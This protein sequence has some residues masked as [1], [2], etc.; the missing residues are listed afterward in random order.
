[1]ETPM[2][3][4]AICRYAQWSNKKTWLRAHWPVVQKG[5]Q[6][7]RTM[8]EQSPVGT[9]YAGLMPPGFIDGGISTKHSDYGATLWA[10]VAIEKGIAAA[11]W[12]GESKDEKDWK[13]LFDQ[14][15]GSFKTAARRDL[16]RDESGNPYLPVIV[17][18]TA[19]E[20]P[21]RGQFA[22]LLP[23]C[24]SSIFQSHDSLLDSIIHFN[25]AMLD[26]TTKEGLISN[27]GWMKDGLW[28]WLGGIHGMAHHL[29][30]NNQKAID[31]LYAVA[32]H[33]APTG[34]WVEEQQQKK[35]GNNTSGDA[36]NAEASAIFIHFVR[37]LLVREKPD[38]LEFLSGVPDE[39]IH[40]GAVIEVNNGLTE[41][42]PVTMKLQIS[43]DGKRGD[44][45]I[46]GIDGH[47]KKGY[48]VVVLSALK[49]A[50]F[51][52]ANGTPLPDRLVG[53]WKKAMS[54]SVISTK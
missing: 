1:I 11:R 30:G 38:T 47:G 15:M 48:P 28:P 5:I 19:L 18:D 27:S 31:L 4:H 37:N 13:V 14:F 20:V 36:S 44:L 46:S 33:A 42:G 43:G 23:L 7:L 17:G 25:L 39:W 51:T 40:R 50:G 53:S 6:W 32:N 12:L 8:R 22:I 16:R 2:Y 41:F 3:V 26:A 9:S 35:D 52:A 24:F 34:V 49:R 45:R 29:A 10:M 21:Q 54:L